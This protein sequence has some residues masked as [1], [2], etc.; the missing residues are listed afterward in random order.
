[1]LGRAG[2]DRDVLWAMEE[3]LGHPGVAAVIGEVTALARRPGRRLQ[4]AAETSGVPALVLHRPRLAPSG[5]IPPSSAATRWR[6]AAL[7]G[8]GMSTRWRVELLRCRG[9][10]PG[11]FMMEWSDATDDDPAGHFSLAAPFRGGAVAQGPDRRPGGGGGPDGNLVRR[12]G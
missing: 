11:D 7:P 2:D 3:A 1:M 5:R 4:L 10:K 12:A 6:V 9:G 8:D